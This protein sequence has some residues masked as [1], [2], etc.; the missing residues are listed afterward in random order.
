MK[1]NSN[2]LLLQLEEKNGEYEYRHHSV[3]KLDDNKKS[4]AEKFAKKYLREFYGNKADKEGDG[5]Y[6]H[7]GEVFVRLSNWKLISE[8]EY[9]V[10][11]NYL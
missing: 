5:Y 1:N 9:N 6:Y 8:D 4:S 11:K 3:H 7:N 2:Y 10:L